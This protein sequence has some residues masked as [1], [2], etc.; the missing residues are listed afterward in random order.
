MIDK[1]VVNFTSAID[2]DTPHQIKNTLKP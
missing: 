2:M 1:K